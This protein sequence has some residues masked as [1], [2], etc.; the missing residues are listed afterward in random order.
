MAAQFDF[1]QF[2]TDAVVT[3]AASGIGRTIADGLV[4]AGVAVS[5]WDLATDPI[6]EWE[7]AVTADR[8]VAIGLHLDVTDEA[9]IVEAFAA[10]IERLGPVGFLVNNAGPAS[11]T[12]L[13]FARGLTLAAGSVELVT[14]S[15]LETPGSAGGHEH[16]IG[17]RIVRRRRRTGVVSG[18][19]G[20]HRRLHAQP[21]SYSSQRHPRQRHRTGDHRDAQNGGGHRDR[22][23]SGRPRP[24]SAR[25]PRMS[26]GRRERGP[27][28]A[29]AGLRLRQ[30]V[31]LPVDGGSLL[32]L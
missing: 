15:W 10:T 12:E 4:E 19:E 5:G 31:L 20:S 11:T 16:L 32:T 17:R 13:P 25:P 27:V 24:D 22:G 21:G 2:P 8:G 1:L 18:G 29:R 6:A 30:R 7:S 28:P 14:R 23:R 26:H 3:G 9:Q